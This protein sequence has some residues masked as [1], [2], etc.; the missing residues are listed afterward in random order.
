MELATIDLIIIIL[1]LLATIAIGV[2][3]KKRAKASKDA[4]MLGGKSLPWYLLGLSNASDMFDI[5]GT[6]WMVTL[7]FVYGLKS[8][9]I[10]WLWP[11]FN[12]VF[13]MVYLSA[14]LRRSNVTTGA[15]WISTRFG[16]G[17]GAS[18]SPTDGSLMTT[19][20]YLCITDHPIRVCTLPLPLLTSCWIM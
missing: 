18:Y 2:I 15:E 10:P 7:A 1:Y 17:R 3:L 9:W 16:K 19:E 4:Y 20:K 13:M 11:S 14:W 5:S 12:Q 8:I 6:M